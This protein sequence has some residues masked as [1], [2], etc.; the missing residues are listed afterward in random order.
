MTSPY[1]HARIVAIDC[2]AARAVSG[3]HAVVTGE[4]YP[5]L[6]GNFVADRP[7][8]AFGKI[9]Y[10]GEPVA[11]V[12]A[13]TERLAKHAA[14]LIRLELEPLPVVQ[15][16]SEALKP[17]APLV[18]EAL[19]SYRRFGDTH[20][21]P[22]TNIANRVRI[23]KGDMAAGWAASDVTAE[24]S[25]AFN[26]ADHAAMEPRC[27]IVEAMPDG[28]IDV[29]T[30]TQ[31]PYILKRLFNR[32]FDADQ[33]KVIVHTPLVGG[34]FGG[35]GS[36][37]LEYVAYLASLAC[38]GRPVKV[39]NT[40][41]TDMVSAPCHIG[42]EARVKLGATRDGKLTAAEITLLFDNGGYADIGT[43]VVQSAAADCTGPY[44]I[45]NVRCDALGVYTNHPYATAF[46]GFGHLENHFCIERTMDLLAKKLGLDPLE[47]RARNAILPGDT[48]PTQAPLNRSNLGDLPA[49]IAKL[50]P[51]IRW[52]EGDRVVIGRDRVRAKGY[53]CIWKTS[54]SQ[55][56]SG[57]GAFLTFNHDGS[58][59]LSVGAVELGQGNRTVM[60]QILA[61]RMRVP[62]DQVH[63]M[64]DVDTQVTPEHWKT[65]AS[66]STMMVGRAVLDAADDA[67]AQLKRNASLV[68]GVPVGE[69]DY[70]DGFVFVRAEPGRRLS[71][72][73]LMS[74]Y[75]DA[76]GSAVG[77]PVLGRGRYQV[78]GLT[79]MN[80][81]T[82]KGIPGEQWTVG[83]EAVEVEYNVRDCTYRLLKAVSVIDAGKV[84]NEGTAR[85]QVT[86][87]MSMGLSFATR[88]SFQ[89]DPNG[90]VLNPQLRTYKVIRY[91]ETPEYVAAFVETPYGEGPF[92]A[93][94]ISEHGTIGMPAALANALSVAA[95]AQ[96]NRLPLTPETIW[97]CT[98]G[99]E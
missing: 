41:E 45:D 33:S 24:G 91:G 49:C 25:Y 1:A 10:F 50:K 36:V 38:G 80:P 9:R 26:N 22:G 89:Y 40:R 4:D 66:S 63:V 88:E 94:G 55:I 44:R 85:G 48:S 37:Y 14:S 96:L 31:D 93:R 5:V 79:T 67:I 77:E 7:P 73:S 43:I 90:V 52:D 3:V 35:K 87:A 98:T 72:A 13:E 53:A 12:V 92:G 68:F 70:G 74:G 19:G 6:T 28:T 59:N 34:G 11:V 42:L 75:M 86:G 56:D 32:F 82:G 65:V 27:S 84:I 21:V 54:G 30:S 29:T 99:R 16:P 81:E 15:S 95:G 23:R 60:A 18:H 20:P 76:N 46:R 97:R 47:L 83:A 57:S 61:E 2:A 69:L 51:L 64:L 8:V 62:V 71:F 39:N 17:D 58:M 78:H